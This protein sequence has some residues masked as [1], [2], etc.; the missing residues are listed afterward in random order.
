MYMQ[1]V[2]NTSETNKNHKNIKMY[3]ISTQFDIIN[4]YFNNKFNKNLFC[5]RSAMCTGVKYIYSLFID[6][7]FFQIFYLIYMLG[8]IINN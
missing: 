2:I 8:F 5:L 3:I 4:I 7:I 1:K 6:T